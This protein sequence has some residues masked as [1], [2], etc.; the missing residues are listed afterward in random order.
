MTRQLRAIFAAAAL[1]VVAGCSASPTSTGAA[2]ATDWQAN[3]VE[4]DSLSG[5]R[6]PNMMGSGN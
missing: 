2:A 1:V 3:T 6:I 4:G 5:G